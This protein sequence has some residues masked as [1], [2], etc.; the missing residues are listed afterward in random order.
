MKMSKGK[1]AIAAF[2]IFIIAVLGLFIP[3]NNE[4]NQHRQIEK[5][6]AGLQQRILL[7]TLNKNNLQKEIAELNV[8]IE[9]SEQLSS[10]KQAEIEILQ[11]Q[12]DALIDDREE[13]IAKALSDLSIIQAE[14]TTEDRSID[15]SE[16]LF[17]LASANEI[18]LGNFK[19]TDEGNI[20]ING[21]A[22]HKSSVVL[23]ATGTRNDILKYISQ[24]GKEAAFKTA[25][26]EDIH[27]ITPIPL[28]NEEKQE[29][30][31]RTL[32][33]LELEAVSRFTIDEIVDFIILG[34]AKVTDLSFNVPDMEDM[35]AAIL[36][37]LD[38]LV[39]MQYQEPLAYD[40]AVIIKQHIADFII[41]EVVDPLA[42]DIAN[43]ITAGG[44]IAALTEL[45]GEDIVELMGDR[46]ASI[47]PAEIAELLK[48]YIA[49]QIN[50][51]MSSAV[52]PLIE[53]KAG[54]ISAGRIAQMETTE[55]ELSLVIY[56]YPEA[57]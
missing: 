53:D 52:I 45:F 7:L 6:I 19:M 26:F 29:I 36:S 24:I 47:L 51:E 5:D 42:L 11:S 12:L 28:I 54:D 34:I 21:V 1:W 22:Y 40:L 43:A 13:A 56:T 49:M 14:Y 3:Y 44:D 17:N 39:A 32:S 30:Y 27:I 48:D 33:E 20:Y 9:D 10:Q 41:D 4:R 38:G 18:A 37:H 25:F 23:A 2:I 55:S 16:L 50:L 46:I 15:Y 31:D 57:E 35:A 8:E